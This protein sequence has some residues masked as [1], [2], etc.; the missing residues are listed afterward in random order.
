MS[1]TIENE[2]NNNDN[3]NNNNN[4]DDND[5]NKIYDNFVRN[6]VSVLKKYKKSR[7]TQENI[8]LPLLINNSQKNKRNNSILSNMNGMSIFNKIF[9]QKKYIVP[10][11]KKFHNNIMKT[12]AKR[13]SMVTMTLPNID[14]NN[15]TTIDTN[16]K[17]IDTNNKTIDNNDNIDNNNNSNI[18]NNNNIENNNNNIENDNNNNN[19]NNDNNKEYFNG[20]KTLKEYLIKLEENKKFEKEYHNKHISDDVKLILQNEIKTAKNNQKKNNKKKIIKNNKK[21]PERIVLQKLEDLKS[22]SKGNPL[23]EINQF[24]ST[25]MII[26]DEKLMFNVLKNN[27][28]GNKNNNFNIDF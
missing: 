20:E 7:N 1:T 14:N 11:I 24:G 10:E 4:N 17:T 23:L 15:K 25:P 2:N 28:K 19:N 3:I 5:N 13:I 12:N 6:S 26:K 22:L 16:N 18:D 9:N 27:F 21:I 8:S